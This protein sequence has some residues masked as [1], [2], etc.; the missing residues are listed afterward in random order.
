MFFSAVCHRV[1]RHAAMQRGQQAAAELRM[2]L[3]SNESAL[4]QVSSRLATVGA[5]STELMERLQEVRPGGSR[6]LANVDEK[7]FGR[8]DSYRHVEGRVHRSGRASMHMCVLCTIAKRP[9]TYKVQRLRPTL[10][11]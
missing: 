2:A 1:S 3:E 11:T 8:R 4:R 6:A 9:G 5:E 7:R 10:E